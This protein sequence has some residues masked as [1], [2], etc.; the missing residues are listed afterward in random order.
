MNFDNFSDF[1]DSH[2]GQVVE[3]LIYRNGAR[4]TKKVKF[5]Q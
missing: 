3:L 1:L 4:I 5:A 2:H